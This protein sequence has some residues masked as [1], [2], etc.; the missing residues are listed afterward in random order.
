[1]E[2]TGLLSVIGKERVHLSMSE[3]VAAERARLATDAAA[4]SDDRRDPPV[5]P[6]PD[7]GAAAPHGAS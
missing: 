6:A 5:P 1:M 4:G 3:A 2:R 7:E